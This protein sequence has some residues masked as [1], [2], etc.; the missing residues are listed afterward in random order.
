VEQA[1]E[2][3]Q[4]QKERQ[5]LDRQNNGGT[6]IN[7]IYVTVNMDSVL[8]AKGLLGDDGNELSGGRK[9]AGGNG[10]GD[11]QYASGGSAPVA[12]M[13]GSVAGSAQFRRGRLREM[14]IQNG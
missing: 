1:R 10:D 14:T 12:A 7:N 6:V 11:D 2:G 8:R 9:K 5:G 3:R 13:A 4:R